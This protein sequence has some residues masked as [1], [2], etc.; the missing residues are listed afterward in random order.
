M[1]NRQIGHIT[2]KSSAISYNKDIHL[3]GVT[4]LYWLYIE[5]SIIYFLLKTTCF[6]SIPP[7]NPFKIDQ[8]SISLHTLQKSVMANLFY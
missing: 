2:V 6:F 5:M 3:N 1:H 4:K 7:D 8:F